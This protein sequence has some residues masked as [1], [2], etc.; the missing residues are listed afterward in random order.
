MK[1]SPFPVFVLLICAALAAAACLSPSPPATPPASTPPAA[2]VP[3]E[4]ASLALSPQDLPAGYQLAESRAKNRAEVGSLAASL[5]WQEGYVVRYDRAAGGASSASEITQTITRYPAKNIPAIMAIIG[6][7]EQSDANLTFTAIA[8]PGI[9][10]ASG[11]YIGRAPPEMVV[12][13]DS[14]SRPLVAGTMHAGF[15]QNISEIYFSRNDVMEVVRVTGGE[16]EDATVTGLARNA[17][18]KI[19]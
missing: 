19:P 16:A 10:D 5:G 2:T 9:G 15:R 12:T 1:C 13:E 6:R 3:G 17:S 14:P 4:L 11:G 8:A 7:Q 18:L